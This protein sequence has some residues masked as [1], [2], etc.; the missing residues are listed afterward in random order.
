M[1]NLPHGLEKSGLAGLA[2]VVLA[3]TGLAWLSLQPNRAPRPLPADAALTAF[4]A[5]RALPDFH[6]LSRVP[7]PIASQANAQARGYLLAQLARLGVEHEVQSASARKTSFISPGINQRDDVTLGVSHNV[8]A[9][10]KG[11]AIDRRRRPALLIAS[12]YDSAPGRAGRGRRRMWRWPP[13]SK[14][15]RALG[16]GAPP[17]N[18]VIFLFADGEK[19]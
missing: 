6:A 1:L 5:T 16:H 9:R 2:V 15:L 4:S 14:T 7:R 19:A 8:L 12:H 18:D 13:C 11:A 3:L 17:D 10:I